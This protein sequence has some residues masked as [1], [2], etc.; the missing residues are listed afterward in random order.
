MP[1]DF[2]ALSAPFDPALVSWRVG[3][4]T[5]DK[6]K[7]RALAYIDA[8]DVMRRLDAV[9]GPANWQDRYVPMPN[10][11]TC[12]EIGIRVD[13]EWVWKANGAGNTDI[14]G[15]KGGYSDAFK[16]AAVL[17]GI[18]QYL[19]DLDSP[20]VKLNEWKQIEQHELSKLQALLERN[21]K[22]Q[23]SSHSARQADTW[24]TMVA[25]LE[26]SARGGNLKEYLDSVKGDVAAWPDKWREKWDELVEQARTIE[27]VAA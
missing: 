17:W 27:K 12:C 24:K 13:G 22:P 20:W 16:R 18:G 21:G 3:Q 2:T 26:R 6:S 5:K 14:E 15:E 9:V 10:G 4:L 8:R 7:A 11:T 25:E 19:Y 23:Q 1:V